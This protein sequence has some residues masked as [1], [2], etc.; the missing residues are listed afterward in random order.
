ML[1]KSLALVILSSA[2][3]VW[4]QTSSTSLSSGSSGT[5]QGNLREILGN[6]KFEDSYTLTDAKLRADD[7]SLSR[8]SLK[9]NLSY[10]GPTLSDPSAA[11]QP[12]PDGSPGTYS[13][14]LGGSMT[15][16][17]RFTPDSTMTMGSGLKAN[18]PFHGMDRF[19]LNN[20]FV[21]YDVSSRIGGVQMRNSP[22]VSVVTNPDYTKL[23]E[24]G[25]VNW[26]NSVVYDL[27][28]SHFAVGMDSTAGYYFYNRGYNGRKK[29]GDGNANRYSLT[30]APVIKYNVSDRLNVYTSFG[31]NFWNPRKVQ[32][33]WALWN[34]TVTE[35]IGLGYAFRRDI[36]F[37]PYVSF[38][39]KRMS[40]EG[41]TDAA[42]NETTF[43]FNTVF[44]IM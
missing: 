12:N 15:G 34:R 38:Y 24:Y 22:G 41:T 19:D 35:R 6:K 32:D 7:G 39:P 33:Q 3:V 31:F 8:Y 17:Y 11:D 25:T 40:D 30:M 4:A 42:T 37:A 16:R 36:Y 1:V 44:S 5:T 18:H 20:P 28:R 26:D 9:F 10:Y 43:N 23:G 29:N 13:T 14:A 2:S 27:G 21:S